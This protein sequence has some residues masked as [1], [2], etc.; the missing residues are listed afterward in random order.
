MSIHPPQALGNL[1]GVEVQGAQEAQETHVG[2]I[3]AAEEKDGIMR[4]TKCIYVCVDIERA[5]DGRGAEST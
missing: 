3:H 1:L 2:G 5:W 4:I